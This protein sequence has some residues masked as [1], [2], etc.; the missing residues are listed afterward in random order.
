MA[1][2]SFQP[3]DSKSIKY[4][5]EVKAAQKKEK[6]S[7]SSL[8]TSLREDMV[9]ASDA[10]PAKEPIFQRDRLKIAVGI[11][12]GAVIIG[13][14]LFISV[15]PGRPILERGLAGLAHLDAAATQS[16]TPTLVVPTNTLIPSTHTPLPSPTIQPT[17]TP[18]VAFAAS[19]THVHPTTTP[20]TPACREAT[21]ITLD[22]VG[23][24]LCVEGVV[25]EII[26]HTTDV[27]V[28]F[29]YE[30]GAFYWVSYDLAW[31]EGKAGKCY[32]VD[33]TI[34]RIGNSPMLVFD[35]KNI[36]EACP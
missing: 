36:P 24:S 1:K 17:R 31:S 20:T 11:L 9:P 5:S 8:V 26:P 27:M 34:K 4:F 15:G 33:G 16:M 13:L 35:Y 23:K 12:L 6:V 3:E 32:R 2:K 18:V 28:T 22:D 30:R 25:L 14:L 7:V 10:E 19:P 29:S 21:S